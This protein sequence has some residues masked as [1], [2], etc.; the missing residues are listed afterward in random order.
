MDTAERKLIF[1]SPH[2]AVFNQHHNN[3][4]ERALEVLHRLY[5]KDG[6][7]RL[8]SALHHK[9]IMAIF[10]DTPMDSACRDYA[11][12]CFVFANAFEK[13]YWV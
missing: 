2:W 4:G 5:D 12:L 9:R 13:E 1:P 8:L 10:H 3:A 6:L 7:D 11:L